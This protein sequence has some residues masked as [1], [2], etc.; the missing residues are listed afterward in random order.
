MLLVDL[1]AFAV[2]LQCTVPSLA[3]LTGCVVF[4]RAHLWYFIEGQT[5]RLAGLVIGEQSP[6]KM[7]C[8]CAWYD[9]S[10]GM[11]VCSFVDM[12]CSLVCCQQQ[13]AAA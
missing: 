2:P 5:P 11:H 10:G 4:G 8:P 12:Y 7:R 6:N 9:R 13:L 3:Q 1:A